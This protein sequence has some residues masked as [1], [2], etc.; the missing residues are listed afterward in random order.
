MFRKNIKND[1]P[2]RSLRLCGE[3]IFGFFASV[4]IFFSTCEFTAFSAESRIE[5]LSAGLQRCRLD[6][7]LICLIKEDK[8]A[9]LVSIQIWVG[10]GSAQE[11]QYLGGGL[12]HLI[13]HMIFKGTPRRKP[14][15]IAGQISDAGGDINA[16]TSLDRT[17]FHVDLPA[18]EWE[19]GL[20]ILADAVLNASFP[21]DEWRREKEVVR[22]EMAM[23]NDDPGRVISKLLWQ[24]AFLN[25]PYRFP[26]IGRPEIFDGLNR[27]DL[28]AFHRRNYTP[29]NMIISVVG[30]V[31]PAKVLKAIEKKFP[32]NTRARPQIVLTP[33]PPQIGPRSARQT[34]DYNISR[35]E[36]AWHTV[37][38][39]NPDAPALDMLAMIAGSGKSALLKQKIKEEQKLC[40][41]IDVWSFTPKDEGLFGIS[42]E[43]DPTNEVALIKAIEREVAVWRGEKSE[44]GGPTAPRAGSSASKSV[45]AERN[46]HPVVVSTFT[47]K[48]IEKARNR[49]L[50]DTLLAFQTMHGRAD[51]F[52]SGEFYAGSP[53]YFKTYLRRLDEVTPESLTAAAKK[54]L[55]DQNRTL[56]ILS[57]TATNETSVG[58]NVNRHLEN[59]GPT[60]P[61]AG[62]SASKSVATERDGHLMN[63]GKFVFPNGLTVLCHEDKNLPFVHICIA[64]LGGL[65]AENEKN[66]G[67]TCLT[68]E[69]LTR[70]TEQYGREK[71]A[72]LVEQ[73]GGTLSPF[74]G[75]NSYGLQARCFSKDVERFMAIAADC[76][77]G[78][79]F[80][81]D[82]IKKCKIVQI[83]GIDQEHESPVFL[84]QEALRKALFPGHPYSMNIE[85]TRESVSSITRAD[86]AALHRSLATGSNTV[87]AVFGDIAPDQAK[88]LAAKYF[89]NMPAGS[90]AGF[91]LAEAARSKKRP[92]ANADPASGK[93][94]QPEK[95]EIIVPREQAVVLLGFP[96]LAVTDKRMDACNIMLSALNGLS[97]DL[98]I[99]VR[100]KR[101]LAYYTGAYQRTGLAG[102]QFV[103]YAGTRPQ[104]EQNVGILIEKEINRICG[105]GIR[106]EEF[107]RA[108]KDIIMQRRQ[109]EQSEGE[110]ARECALNEL[111]GLGYAH[112]LETENRL[113]KVS[114]DDVRRLADEIL[115]MNKAVE[116][117]V[118]PGKKD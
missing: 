82:E 21:E 75:M 12:S 20:D 103:A 76:W 73:E 61:R 55:T 88:A 78:A 32:K 72:E 114:R 33:E 22:R 11:E 102:G 43:F 97:S 110:L 42:A 44:N 67:I 3:K 23:G 49:M 98:M 94:R 116:V 45:A 74:S 59:G 1:L 51:A 93:D 30:D 9:P 26:V 47:A 58:K 7:G 77:L 24:T 87:V 8:S 86:I 115:R 5:Q 66:N 52:A 53:E 71:I 69:L 111:Y 108:K 36:M 34:G 80:P 107:K 79:N 15:E 19:T 104:A 4:V 95:I 41:E 57:P 35:L 48:N 56:A 105:D 83:A 84:G 62:A 96:G 37:G 28:T 118:K 68:A 99:N 25:H 18:E 2:L 117:V 50:A 81:E 27:N 101:G 112:G 85:G 60:A 100:D 91:L 29:D 54:Y 65:P 16:Y 13:E 40:F 17:V 109:S 70:G 46:G 39:S 113:G 63:I 10:A 89:E 14:S 90:G 31:D 6:N 64:S 106:P 38:L 92:C